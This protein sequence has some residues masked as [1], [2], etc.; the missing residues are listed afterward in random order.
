VING[1]GKYYGIRGWFK[2]LEGRTYKMHVRVFLARYR[3]YRIC[4]DCAGGR[5]KSDA[6]QYR[7]DGRTVVDVNRMSVADAAAFF[8]GL[9]LSSTE[10][11]IASLILSEI[12]HRLRYLLAVGLDYLTLDRQ[13]R[14][15]SA[16]SWRAST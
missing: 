16:A 9:R 5:L 15:L 11:E 2:W 6:L 14:T 7:I 3:S 13:S 12:R 4:P 1:E 8:A 10:E